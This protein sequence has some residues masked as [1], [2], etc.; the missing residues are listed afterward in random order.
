MDAEREVLLRAEKLTIPG[1][2]QPKTVTMT[3]RV[4]DAVGMQGLGDKERTAFLQA[5]ARTTP[6]AEGRLFWGDRFV[7][8][9]VLEDRRP[10]LN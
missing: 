4:G 6:I 10:W 3:L 2:A 1:A 5:L 7:A 9:V 8:E